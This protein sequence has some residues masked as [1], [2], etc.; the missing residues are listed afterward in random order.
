M[1]TIGR[2]RWTVAA[3]LGLFGGP[4]YAFTGGAE[5]HERITHDALS[6]VRPELVEEAVYWNN[7][8]DSGDPQ[9]DFQRH[10]DRCRFVEGFAY[11]N[12]QLGL[13][14]DGLNPNDPDPLAFAKQLG[15]MLHGTQDFYSHANWVNLVEQ[16]HGTAGLFDPANLF[17]R[18]TRFWAPRATLGLI[19]ED[20]VLGERNLDLTSDEC[21]KP[22]LP[23][24]GG[25]T[26]SQ[27]TQSTIPILVSPTG[28]TFRGLITHWGTDGEA[29]CLDVRPE[30][31]LTHGDSDDTEPEYVALN[32]DASPR[33]HWA[34]ALRLATWQSSQAWC[35]TLG[36]AFDRYGLGGVGAAM[37][38]VAEPGVDAHPFGT[39]CA[40]PASP[41]PLELKL[42]LEAIGTPLLTTSAATRTYGFAVFTEDLT[43]SRRAR[44]D[45]PASSQ[46]I[47]IGT[48]S[49]SLCVQP[50]QRLGV[51]LFGYD[52]LGS[53]GVIDEDDLLMQGVTGTLVATGSAATVAVGTPSWNTSIRYRVEYDVTD[54]DGDGWSV[55]EEAAF[56]GSD[57]DPDAD[58]DG[59]ADGI[60]DKFGG[61]PF[62]PD[63]DDDGASDGEEAE[64]GSDP[65]LPDTDG[66]GLTD[67]QEQDCG[68]DPTSGWTAG[69]PLDD[70]SLCVPIAGFDPDVDVDGL[71]DRLEVDWELDPKGFDTDRDGVRDG[72]DPS[73]LADAVWRFDVATLAVPKGA[74][75]T[76]HR[77]KIGDTAIAAE[78]ALWDGDPDGAVKALDGLW[79]A[80][81]GCDPGKPADPGTGCDALQRLIGNLRAS[82]YGK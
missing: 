44:F 9:D 6:F 35:Q 2:T 22:P 60:E 80:F 39:T 58:D 10:F 4:G 26:A 12:Q 28:Q 13:A 42:T 78:Q 77:A 15:R 72:A 43:Q 51:S 67:G 24:T 79:T 62:D 69:N 21:Y 55:C 25:W 53:A 73:W 18:S 20:I 27:S 49:M 11:V 3:A 54:G 38:L 64:A 52:E 41:G 65:R 31:R 70:A 76:D 34:D 74:S 81:V 48:V 32:K 8:Q 71:P 37:T 14:A 29:A 17:D 7:E 40:P 36:I 63:T 57:A 82:P 5:G 47:P 59:L 50:N 68:T 75:D 19:R 1:S 45:V 30:C 33:P 61:D 16:T 66:D 23:L 56:G 46:T